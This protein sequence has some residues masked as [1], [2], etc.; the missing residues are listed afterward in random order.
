MYFSY[1]MNSFLF[2]FNII[3]LKLINV[4]KMPPKY[5][6]E[7]TFQSQKS[8]LYYEIQF[9]IFPFSK[10]HK[11]RYKLQIMII[12]LLLNTKEPLFYLQ[13][14]FSY[15]IKKKSSKRSCYLHKQ[16]YKTIVASSYKFKCHFKSLKITI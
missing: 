7:K 9:Y 16:S 1:I 2:S 5:N 15:K 4:E 13:I 6:R 12:N 8:S 14:Y 11:F 3:N 10:H